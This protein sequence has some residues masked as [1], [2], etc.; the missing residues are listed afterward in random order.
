MLADFHDDKYGVCGGNN[1]AKTKIF[2]QFSACFL[3]NSELTLGTI[4][5]ERRAMGSS[6]SS[7]ISA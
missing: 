4:F 5:V 3:A 2:P 7:L 1:K 6:I